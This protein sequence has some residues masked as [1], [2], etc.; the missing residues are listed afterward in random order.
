MKANDPIVSLAYD[1]S[2]GLLAF[3]MSR[4][5]SIWCNK[6]SENRRRKWEQIERVACPS[7]ELT[8]L[9]FFGGYNKRLFI[10]AED[11]FG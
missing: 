9:K 10:G 1:G 4:E 7:W 5:F 2:R 8:S 3:A 11:G 6:L